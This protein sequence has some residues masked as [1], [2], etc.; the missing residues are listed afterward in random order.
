MQ[1][2]DDERI[3]RLARSGDLD[4]VRRLLPEA[5]RRGEQ[6][7]VFE[8]LAALGDDFDGVTYRGDLELG[9]RCLE[10]FKHLEVVEG[11]LRLTLSFGHEMSARRQ[12]LRAS[13]GE[14]L[15]SVQA[16]EIAKRSG[17]PNW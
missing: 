13:G 11:H 10:D 1:A 12:R 9:G 15:K 17:D 14:R 5:R 2:R 8:L 4:A 16:V 3:R 7:L 6:A